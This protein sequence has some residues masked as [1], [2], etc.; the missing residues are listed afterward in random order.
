MN[1]QESI[2]IYVSNF[3]EFPIGP[4]LVGLAL[5]SQTMKALPFWQRWWIR[6]FRPKIWAETVIRYQVVEDFIQE[7]SEKAWVAGNEIKYADHDNGLQ[8]K[9]GKADTGGNC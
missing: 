2:D 5:Q 9:I 1:D 8:F 4:G 3:N 7:E 6:V